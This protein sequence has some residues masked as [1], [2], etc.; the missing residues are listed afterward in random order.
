[1]PSFL[2][3]KGKDFQQKGKENFLFLICIFFI[4]NDQP[5]NTNSVVIYKHKKGVKKKNLRK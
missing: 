1:M 3:K 4:H 5:K 2:L